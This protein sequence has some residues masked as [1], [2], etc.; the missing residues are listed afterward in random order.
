MTHLAR[1]VK[2]VVDWIDTHPR[3]GWYIAVVVTLNFIVSVVGLF[4]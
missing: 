1:F 2:P 3:T 4:S